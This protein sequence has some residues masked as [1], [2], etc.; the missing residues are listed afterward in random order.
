[1]IPVDNDSLRNLFVYPEVDYRPVS[2]PHQSKF[3]SSPQLDTSRPLAPNSLPTPS[4]RP[5]S[6]PTQPILRRQSS[7]SKRPRLGECDMEV[8]HWN[9]DT[10]V[11]CHSKNER[12][13]SDVAVHQTD[14]P[15]LK[16]ILSFIK[17]TGY[18]RVCDIKSI[19]PEQESV[20]IK[21]ANILCSLQ[22]LYFYIPSATS[23]SEE[24]VYV[25]KKE[26]RDS[27]VSEIIP[28]DICDKEKE[29][30]SIVKKRIEVL[31]QMTL[32]CGILECV[33]SRD[34]VTMTD[35]LR[36]LL[37]KGKVNKEK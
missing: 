19:F 23:S 35:V 11:C 7:D 1:M 22:S 5:N 32:L 2:I 28:K 17:R 24:G 15:L 37:Q 20:V 33:N 4:L 29:E 10:F 8:S 18:L 13:D 9:G 26:D 34:N 25:M 14:L 30:L 21:I 31:E 3:P 6:F 16:S 36:E 12:C 27:D